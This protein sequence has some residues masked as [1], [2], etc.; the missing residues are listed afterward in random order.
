MHTFVRVCSHLYAAFRT[1]RV[2]V[3]CTK[4]EDPTLATFNRLPSGYWRAQVRRKG[5]YVSRS[6]R[7]KSEAEVWATEAERAIHA[8][9]SPDAVSVDDTTTFAAL[10][11]LHI[12]DMAEVGK[13]LLRSKALCLEKLKSDLGRE[14]LGALTRERLIAYGKARAKQGAGPTTIAIDIGYIRTILVHAAAV[15]GI[16]VPTEQVML[17]RVALRRLGLVGK[18]QER[19]RRPTQDELDRII[20]YHDN[21]PRQTIPVGRIVKFAVATAMRQDEICSLL[22]K[23][24]DLT[25]CLAIVRNRKDPRRK[26]GNDQK[27]PLLD[28]T[29]YDAVNLLKQQQA[30]GTGGDRVFPYNGRSLGTAFRRACRDLKIEDLHFHDLR[31]EA[32]SRLFE[33]GFDI[34]EVSLVTGHKDWKMLRRYL[35]LRPHQLIGRAPVSRRY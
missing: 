3:L 13:F 4:Q 7:L 15:H 17:A 22:W 2:H 34:P 32:T 14:P 31:H 35:N 27:V 30:L 26:S 12:N 24:V 33:A 5:R 20:A 28:A 1:F 23:D 6:F 9:K 21:N 29:G 10:L 16:E 18:S 8:G 11:E 19:D 25:T